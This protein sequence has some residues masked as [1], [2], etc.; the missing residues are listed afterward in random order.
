MNSWIEPF[1]SFILVREVLKDDFDN[2]F[3]TSTDLSNWR[4]WRIRG[5]KKK[6][7][8]K[9]KYRLIFSLFFSMRK[10]YGNVKKTEIR[11]LNGA[12]AETRRWCWR[13]LCQCFPLIFAEFVRASICT[14]HLWTTGFRDD[15]EKTCGEHSTCV[16]AKKNILRLTYTNIVNDELLHIL[17]WKFS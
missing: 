8:A 3:F 7:K 9:S 10:K 15:A 4:E 13:R 14:K 5:K 17:Y 11:K 2:P 6:V 1:L 16:D 12:E